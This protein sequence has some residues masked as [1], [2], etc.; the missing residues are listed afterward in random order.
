[1]SETPVPE[2]L[3][4][5]SLFGTWHAAAW[6][7]EAPGQVDGAW[8]HSPRF[9]RGWQAVS[10]KATAAVAEVTAERDDA[11]AERDGATS[12][13]DRIRDVYRGVQFSGWPVAG[14]KVHEILLREF[15]DSKDDGGHV[16]DDGEEP[17]AEDA[18]SLDDLEPRS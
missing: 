2:G 4:A 1:M 17:T 11:R 13:L 12:V 15:G 9:R 7:D 10:G 16:P 3:D 14:V 5:R 6:T 8:V 18:A